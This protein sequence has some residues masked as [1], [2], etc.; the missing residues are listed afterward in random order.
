MDHKQYKSLTDKDPIK[1]KPRT[2]PLPKASE[3]YLEAFDRLKEILDRMEIKYEEY[4]HFKSTKHWR[5][6]LHLV[7]YRTLI[8]IAGGPWSGGRK[9]K[10][11]NKAWSVDK[12]DHAEEMGYRF[13]RFEISDIH[14]AIATR[15]LRDLKASHGTAIQTIPAVGSD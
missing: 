10:L 9:G 13:I 7:G 15:W 3:K 11:A 6:D 2:R 12:Y 1:T 5:F 14:S 8:E 4:F